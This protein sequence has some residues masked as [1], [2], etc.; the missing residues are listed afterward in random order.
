[1]AEATWWRKIAPRGPSRWEALNRQWLP[2]CHRDLDLLAGTQ[3]N[4]ARSDSIV[5]NLEMQPGQLWLDV[6]HRLTIRRPKNIAKTGKNDRKANGFG[7][8]HA[9]RH[10]NWDLLKKKQTHHELENQRSNKNMQHSP[11]LCLAKSCNIWPKVEHLS[12]IRV[13][14]LYTCG[15][16]HTRKKHRMTMA[17]FRKWIK[18]LS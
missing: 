16:D 11:K 7:V 18:H 2:L 17:I 8:P 4:K 12:K 13:D 9:S 14:F 15:D 1:M 10:D 3:P 5:S 6:R